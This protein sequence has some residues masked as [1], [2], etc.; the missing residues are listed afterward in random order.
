M[1]QKLSKS[2]FSNLSPDNIISI[3]IDLG[4]DCDGRILALNSYENRV[5]QIGIDDSKPIIVKFYRPERWSDSCIYEEHQFCIDLYEQDIPVVAP[6][7]IGGS[8]LSKYENHRLSIFPCHGGR[9]PELDDHELLIQI[10][11]LIARIHLEG[12]QKR[13]IHR[14]RIDIDTYVI[15]PMEYLLK[16]N[17]IPNQNHEAY[18]S[19]IRLLLNKINTSFD[20]AGDI[21]V[22]R[23]HGD[24]HPGNILINDYKLH[25][26]DFDDCRHGP[27]IQDLWMFLSGDSKEQTPQLNALLEGYKSFRDF[28]P[29]ELHLIEALRSLRIVHYSAWLAKRWND[30]AFKISF[31]WF[32]TSRYW[33]DHILSMREQ[34]SLMQE[35]PLKLTDF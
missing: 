35:E 4:F 16:N 23:L 5:Y 14:P 27:A 2:V 22:L 30:P 10:G 32:N 34:I 8:T 21:Q 12:E 29:L 7:N 28:N 15:K 31:P 9:A 1:T 18:K 13:F 19:V 11:R 24:F 6:I 3:L 20:R 17:F 33:D 26:V 25:I